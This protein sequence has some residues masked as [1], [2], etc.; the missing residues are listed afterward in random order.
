MG[1]SSGR[2]ALLL[3][4]L[5]VPAAGRAAGWEDGEGKDAAGQPV[6]TLTSTFSDQSTLSFE[7]GAQGFTVRVANEGFGT[8]PV[9]KS[10]DAVIVI[11]GEGVTYNPFRAQ[12]PT[13]LGAY[14][15][16]DAT[17]PFMRKLK[18]GSALVVQFRN[19]YLKAPL[20]GIE[21]AIARLGPCLNKVAGYNPLAV[22][23]QR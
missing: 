13:S 17:K 12:S 14:Y 2:A 18:T 9:G 1:R 4:L 11:D 3:L 15:L 8:L 16:Y 22:K 21:P 6:C 19:G 20:A 7:F 5:L 10:Y 23:Q